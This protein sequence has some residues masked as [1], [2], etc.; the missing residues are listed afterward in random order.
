MN[1]RKGG[2]DRPRAEAGM[3]D[4][5]FFFHNPKA[6]GTSVEDA[7]R[8]LFPD[9]RCCPRIENDATE[10]AQR[11]GRYAGFRG[12]DFYAGHYGFDIY[13]AVG[14]G[15]AAA[16]N[17]RWPIDRI[18]S[19]YRYFHHVVELSDS[20]VRDPRFRAVRLAKTLCMDDFVTCDDPAVQLHTH[21][22]HFR[23]L[24]GSGWSMVNDQDLSAARR[25]INQMVWFYVCEHPHESLAWAEEAFC[26]ALPEIPRLNITRTGGASEAGLSARA[27]RQL[28]LQNER[29]IVLYQYALERLIAQVTHE[30]S[31]LVA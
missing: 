13:Q 7:L 6:G 14:S 27:C 29:D 1:A 25:L 28:I 26:R 17:F 9:E 8:S 23:Q 2:V 12:Y 16:T 11:A 20:Q 31:R 5:L 3:A 4:S 18:V 19:V 15:M 22:H 30:P 21:D 10:H 24:T